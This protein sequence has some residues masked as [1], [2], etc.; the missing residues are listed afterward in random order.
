[1]D[2][3]ETIYGMLSFGGNSIGPSGAPPGSLSPPSLPSPPSPLDLDKDESGLGFFYEYE[4][5]V[6][7]TALTNDRNSLLV[8][9]RRKQ[10][11]LQ[12]RERRLRDSCHNPDITASC[13]TMTNDQFNMVCRLNREM[14]ALLKTLESVEAMVARYDSSFYKRL[15]HDSMDY[16]EP[17]PHDLHSAYG[18][19]TASIHVPTYLKP[20][21]SWPMP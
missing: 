13:I 21:S 2:A 19:R 18:T 7:H 16:P 11:D 14:G 12:E 15:E 4:K 5:R 3:P 1:M 8:D 9:I 17:Q 20:S 6:V 10:W